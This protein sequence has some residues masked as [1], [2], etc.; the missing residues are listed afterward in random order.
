MG[1]EAYLEAFR[2]QIE[3]DSVTIAAF[4]TMSGL[5]SK[6]DVVEFRLGGDKSIRR[7]PGRVSFNN[8]TLERGF[9]VDDELWK[10]RKEV[11]D[12]KGEDAKR[13]GAV[14]FLNPDGTE[15]RR[16]NFFR[17]WPVNWEGPSLTA[18]A[19]DTAVEKLELAVEWIEIADGE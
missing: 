7:R 1:R 4:K 5:S 10:W 12:G 8:L 3:V 6:Q 18:G 16:Y 13:T 19:S 11:I 9:T 2:F 14:V 15:A 17:A